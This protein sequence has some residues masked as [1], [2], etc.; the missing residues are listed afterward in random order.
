VVNNVKPQCADVTTR[1][2]K[3]Q[4]ISIPGQVGRLSEDETVMMGFLE[5]R[6][7][8][9]DSSNV[10]NKSG[11]L[12]VLTLS[13]DEIEMVNVYQTEDLQASAEAEFV[14][15]NSALP[16]RVAV[17]EAPYLELNELD[18]LAALTLAEFEN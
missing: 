15:T 18:N 8:Y 3:M 16:I 9:A 17:Y 6:G 13:N 11:L 1:D 10:F 14:R 12:V 2:L 5:F 7:P 4:T